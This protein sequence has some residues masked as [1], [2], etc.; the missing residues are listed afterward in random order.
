MQEY[1]NLSPV[2][3]ADGIFWSRGGLFMQYRGSAKVLQGQ[4]SESRKFPSTPVLS[5]S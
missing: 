4:L 2:T 3:G 5:D 1:N